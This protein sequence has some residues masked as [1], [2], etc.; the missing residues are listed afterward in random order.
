MFVLIERQFKQLAT[1]LKRPTE[2]KLKIEVAP[3]IQNYVTEMDDLYTDLSLERIDDRLIGGADSNIIDYKKIFYEAKGTGRKFL[4]CQNPDSDGERILFKGDPGMGKTTVSK[5]AAYDWAVGILKA[6]T[7]VFFVFLKLVKPLIPKGKLII[8]QTPVLESLQLKD[9]QVESIFDKFSSSCLLIL[10]GLDE[11]AV[12]S[13]EDVLKIIKGQKFRL[14]HVLVT[15]RPHSTRNLESFFKY[16]IRVNGFSPKDAEKFAFKILKSNRLVTEVLAYNPGNFIEN[17]ALNNRPILLSFMCLLVREGQIELSND[18]I[19]TGEVY[20]RM[21]RCLYKKF[22]IRRKIKYQT[23]EFTKAITAVGKIAFCTLLTGNPLLKRSDVIEEVGPDAFDYGLLI[24]HEDAQRLIQDETADIFVTFP[25]RSLQGFLGAFYFIQALDKGDSIES[26]NADSTK[27]LFMTNP[28]FLYF[29]LWLVQHSEPYFTYENLQNVRHTVQ[30]YI[31]NKIDIPHIEFRSIATKFPAIDIENLA[32]KKD[33]GGLKAFGEIMSMCQNVRTVRLESSDSLDGVLMCMRQALPFINYIEVGHFCVM[34]R[35]HDVLFFGTRY[36]DIVLR[37]QTPHLRFP[38][39]A[40]KILLKHVSCFGGDVSIQVESSRE[41]EFLQLLSDLNC[42]NI[43]GI[44]V[45]K[46]YTES[47]V[48]EPKALPLFA[49]LKHLTFTFIDFQTHEIMSLSEAS[50]VGNLPCLTHLN[51]EECAPRGNLSLLFSSPWPQLK[52]LGFH[53][54]FLFIQDFNII[55]NMRDNRFPNLL[56][57]SIT[58]EFLVKRKLDERL[59]TLQSVHLA[60]GGMSEK[61]PITPTCLPVYPESLT[62]RNCVGSLQILADYLFR[63]NLKYLDISFNTGIKGTLSVLVCDIF[64]SLVTLIL[65]SCCLDSQ[66][67]SSLAEA[68]V[69]RRLP[70]LAHLD[71]SSNAL[72]TTEYVNSLF[73]FSCKWNQLLSLNIMNTK[74]SSDELHKRIQSGCL[75]S[76]QELRLSGYPNQTVDVIWLH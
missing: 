53:E 72:D 13:N 31:L 47:F 55:G 8:Q 5:K 10:D 22:I 71:I 32:K 29:C 58:D 70:K 34:H 33:R 67:L 7:I 62:L 14:C 44:H 26:L 17:I 43:K 59:T 52:H 63:K 6:F 40:K 46:R 76:L 69:E 73:A 51:F 19:N 64:P 2:R 11:L 37:P 24:G 23:V 42:T 68:N 54:C 56:S 50:R 25:H 48:N 15:S 12:G 1:K 45:K 61:V 49:Y 27:P 65:C 41:F 16:I 28:L 36:D 9:S 74:F 60:E 38:S 4:P 57:L 30:S 39:E 18:K 20:A 35:V 21:V 66:D 75:S 3:W